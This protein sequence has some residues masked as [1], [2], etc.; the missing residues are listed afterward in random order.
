MTALVH[1]P[2]HHPAPGDDPL[3]AAIISRPPDQK[4]I[5]LGIN[6]GGQL[7]EYGETAHQPKRTLQ[8]D[9]ALSFFGL[10]EIAVFERAGERRK[11]YL[12]VTLGSPH[13]YH[14]FVLSL[15]IFNVDPNRCSWP[16][17]SLLGAL[18]EADKMLDMR[19]MAGTICARRGTKPNVHGH[20]AN[21]IDLF[22]VDATAGSEPAHLRSEAISP[23]RH[24]LE[25]TVDRLRRS[26][27]LEPQFQ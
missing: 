1:D 10:H 5:R 22:L 24:S 19:T 17:R 8:Q 2:L 18:A 7:Y 21:F 16:V 20:V 27:D 26:L 15:P 4:F 3:E 6:Q 13:P 11:L 23:D 25:I 9:E 12:D 14:L